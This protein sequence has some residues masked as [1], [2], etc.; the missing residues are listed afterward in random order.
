MHAVCHVWFAHLPAII[1]R[2][3]YFA[4]CGFC[5]DCSQASLPAIIHTPIPTLIPAVI[6]SQGRVVQAETRPPVR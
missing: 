4:N 2:L 5:A 1:H 6:P 3:I